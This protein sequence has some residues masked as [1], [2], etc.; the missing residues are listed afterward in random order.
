[1]SA[2]NLLNLLL[3][4]AVV[5]LALL[6]AFEPGQAPP[7]AKISLTSLTAKEIQHIEIRHGAST[8]V[9]LEKQDG[10]WR[11]QGLGAVRVS[12]SKLDT[13]LSLA[14]ASSHARYAAASVDRGQT[15]LDRPE[16]QVSLNDT[17]LIFGA[18]EPINGRRYVQVGDSVHLIDDRYSYLL[19]G[20]AASFV[21]SALLPADAALSAIRLPDFSLREEDGHWLLQAGAASP[22]ADALQ[23]FADDWRH[24][25]AL[26]VSAATEKT[27]G[28]KTIEIQLRQQPQPLRFALSQA[29]DETIL[30][31]EDLG[32]SYHFTASTAESLLTLPAPPASEKTD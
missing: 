14:R 5:G 21:D 23:R 12:A 2:R 11:L 16:L 29:D 4:L 6:V 7:P 22:G 26:R 32:L 8:P 17:P 18:T 10:Q 15:G 25:R 13:L 1:M 19:R 30:T 3:A 31:R 9:V 20:D 27:A 24:A 28:A